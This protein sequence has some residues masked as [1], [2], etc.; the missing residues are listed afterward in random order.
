M[1]KFKKSQDDD[2]LQQDVCAQVMEAMVLKKRARRWGFI[3]LFCFLYLFFFLSSPQDSPHVYGRHVAK[4]RVE[5]GVESPSDSWYK[6]LQ[7][8]EKN[9][10][11]IAL[12]LVV[13]S[14]GG[15]VSV[16][17]SGYSLLKR[18]HK[19]V[20]VVTVVERQAAS[21]GYLLAS[22]ADVIFAKE[23]SI[24]GS[25]GVLLQIPVFKDLLKNIGVEYS[26]QGVG[27]SLDVVPFQ[28]F[29]S[30]TNKYLDLAGEDSYRWFR[31]TVQYERQMTEDE[32]KMVIG[33][34][35]FLGS[36]ALSLKLIDGIG[37]LSHAKAWLR[38]HDSS[39]DDRTPLVDY[40]SFVDQS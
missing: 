29:N 32:I 25:I 1:A 27:E 8:V 30:F 38:R 15:T 37:D 12:V 2:S 35:I 26:N 11:V 17:D 19:R 16:A 28:G 7:L 21:A 6:Q 20:P 23:T 24:V 14:P 34:K 36:E 9:S 18:I 3:I 39:I 31:K 4:V 13:D 40:A 5:G 33:G 10:D 22:T